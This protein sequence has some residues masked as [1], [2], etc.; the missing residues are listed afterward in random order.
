MYA[1]SALRS[2]CASLPTAGKLNAHRRSVGLSAWN[3]IWDLTVHHK[4]TISL[5]VPG[6]FAVGLIKESSTCFCISLSFSASSSISFTLALIASSSCNKGQAQL[7]N[8]S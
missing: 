7:N 5:P 2:K 4:H 3:A 6:P 8:I 1:K